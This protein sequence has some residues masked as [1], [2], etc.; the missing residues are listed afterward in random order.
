MTSK[1][2]LNFVNK[3]KFQI[4]AYQTMLSLLPVVLDVAE[5]FNGKVINKRFY[6][7]LA[8]RIDIKVARVG[9]SYYLND[10]MEISVTER[11]DRVSNSY[12]DDSSFNIYTPTTTTKKYIGD[13]KRLDFPLFKES[14]EYTATL[15]N[16][17]INT[18]QDVIDGFDGYMEKIS[19]L[20]AIVDKV[21]SEIPYPIRPRVHFDKRLS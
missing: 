1:S 14:V 4:K 16:E 8:E 21:L 10:K 17:R 6:D 3:T 15:I 12:I 5:T 19:N 7:R 2:Q 13:D 18:L 9:A 11:W 20:E